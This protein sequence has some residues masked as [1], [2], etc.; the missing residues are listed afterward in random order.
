MSAEDRTLLQ[1]TAL[2][3]VAERPE[4]SPPPARI[5][6]YRVCEELASG[7]FGAVYR[8]E[9]ETTGA[10][11]AIKIL[12]ADLAADASGVRRFE[13][14]V[15]VMRRIQHP[16]LVEV[17]ELGRLDDGRPYF[18][19]ELLHGVTLQ[20]HLRAR[21]RLPVDEVIAIVSPLVDALSAA[22]ERSVIHRDIKDSNVFLADAG[23]RRRVVLLD[24]GIA[25]LLD[26][27]G[28]GLTGSRQSIGTFA[29]MS[30]EQLLSQPVDARTDVYAL[31]A[32]VY[33]ML[34]GH[35]PFEDAPYLVMH[36]MHLYARPRRPSSLAPVSPAFDDVLLRAMSKAQAGR[37]PSAAAFRDELEAA[38]RG[39]AAAGH[40]LVV[41]RS[42]IAVRF[43]ARI[44]SEGEGELPEDTEGLFSDLEALPSFVTAELAREGL[45]VVMDAGTT[46]LL[47]CDRPADRMRDIELR[48]RVLGA[49]ADVARRIDARPSRDARVHTSFWVHISTLL[50]TP[51]GTAVGGDVL[52]FAAWAPQPDADGVLVSSATLV[53]I[54]AEVTPLGDPGDSGFVRLAPPP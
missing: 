40:P 26:A 42:V 41:E 23:G 16:S 6:K 1:P 3:G 34:A 30:P 20:A 43:E 53:G 51:D 8:A 48:S 15:E 21:G 52:D 24:F 14:E 10:G 49:C 2:V 38:A 54:S 29:S 44:V 27:P 18:V 22:H 7:G 4:A 35:P 12:H 25:K 39:S 33:R 9:D 5:G 47:A 32:L 45:T 31:G 17:L 36:H 11:A 13:L 28:P 46:R 50:A 37:Q 19:M